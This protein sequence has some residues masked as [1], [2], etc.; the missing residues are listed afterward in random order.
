MPAAIT[1]VMTETFISDG[2]NREHTTSV[3][4][5]NNGKESGMI[6]TEKNGK[7]KTKKLNA[8]YFKTL[9]QSSKK[10]KK[11]ITK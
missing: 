4:Q 3:Y 11:A 9:H 1:V 10:G 5:N 7:V 6:R 8:T 2:K